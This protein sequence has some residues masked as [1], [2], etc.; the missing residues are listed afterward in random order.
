[1][2][3]ILA[4]LRSPAYWR[5]GFSLTRA[6]QA[7]L[8][9]FGTMWLGAEIVSFFSQD[10]GAWLRR[11]WIPFL[12]GGVLLALWLNRPRVR[13]A[14]RLAGRDVVVEIRVGDM[15]AMQ[16]ALV[17]GSNTSFDTD[18][19][20]GLI[21]DSSVQG[22]FTKRYY[23][24]VSHLD[25]DLAAA[26][27]GIAPVR[28]SATKKGKAQV[29]PIG[30]TVHVL[31][32]Q[33]RAYFVAIAAMNDHGVA[34][35]TF[36]DL[37]DSLPMLWDYVATKSGGIEPLIVPVLGSGFSRLPQPREEIIRAIVNSFIAA[38]SSA[39]PTEKLTVVIPFKDFH[40]HQVDFVELERYIQHVCRYT[41]YRS[42]TA[43]GT[44]TG[45]SL[46]SPRQA[47]AQIQQ[48]AASNIV[49]QGGTASP[50]LS[51]RA[52][53]GTASVSGRL[54]PSADVVVDNSG[55]PCTLIAYATLADAA[56][57]LGRPSARWEYAPRPVKGGHGQSVY[58]VATLESPDSSARR[59]V[60]VRGEA[61][62]MRERYETDGH[63]WF[64]VAWEFHVEVAGHLA[65]VLTCSS[66]VSLDEHRGGFLI[67]VRDRVAFADGEA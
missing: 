32:Q 18:T 48:V 59:L 24:A 50:A 34:S 55:G 30:T 63:L 21:A 3:A 57:G 17:I 43:V 35:G 22:Q 45:L 14:C 13:F 64:E 11:Q 15:F 31:A 42:P 47:N 23:S 26:L 10:G 33:R 28:T 53:A 38:C 6:G 5:H 52:V 9:S 1:M 60:K 19:A 67:D 16:G 20:G 41:E 40:E 7:L 44:G 66:H 61:M 12:V 39:R 8:S 56:A 62:E 25:G 58:S 27:N 29:Y 4:A 46:P 2:K 36:D 49:S 65:K 51:V 37:K 54:L